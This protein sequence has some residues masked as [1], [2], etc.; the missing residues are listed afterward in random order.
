MVQVQVDPGYFYCRAPANP[1]NRVKLVFSIYEVVSGDI[2]NGLKPIF[3][4]TFILLEY[5]LLLF[6]YLCMHVFR[7]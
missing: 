4:N 1:G 5:T 6:P 3:G 2:Y 7:S